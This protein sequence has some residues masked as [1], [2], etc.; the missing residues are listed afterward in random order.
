MAN[1]GRL[2]CINMTLPLGPMAPPGQTS[3]PKSPMA[4]VKRIATP[5]A[6]FTILPKSY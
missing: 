3:L 1:Y 4:S 2:N 5:F 6:H